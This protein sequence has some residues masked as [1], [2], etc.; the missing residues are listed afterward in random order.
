MKRIILLLILVFSAS[1][2]FAQGEHKVNIGFD[3]GLGPHYFNS[4]RNNPATYAGAF[5]YEYLYLGII[6]VEVG[7]KIG[8]FNQKVGYDTS[9]DPDY[10]APID[11]A[12][13]A[14][15]VYR[16]MFFA[17]FIAPKLYIPVSED[18]K[19]ARA[20]KLFI[21]NRFMFTHS[22]LDLDRLENIQGK[23]IDNH[24][25][26]EV[27]VG[28]LYPLSQHV[29]A[30]VALGYST[31]NFGRIDRK[32]IKFKNTTPISLGLGLSYTF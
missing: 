24:F 12:H 1:V 10:P 11:P 13:W 25:D 17:P 2:I 20:R 6:S 21:E 26:Y 15:D 7:A 19:L 5:G 16:G 32:N 29:N 9:S 30:N 14:R 27:R 18:H 28:F 31:Y 8:G 22:R 3:L 23:R 4:D